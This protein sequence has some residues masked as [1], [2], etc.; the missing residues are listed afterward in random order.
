[1]ILE[2]DCWRWLK[3][4]VFTLLIILTSCNFSNNSFD[5]EVQGHRGCRGLMPENTVPAFLKAVELGVPVLELDVVISEDKQVV[6]SHEAYFNHIIST[7]P[8]GLEITQN[9][10]KSHIL[11]Y[12]PY[13]TI[14][15]YDVGQK[16][17]PS[18]PEQEKLAVY[19]P[20]LSEVVEKSDAH[21]AELKK[22]LPK[23][24]IEIKRIKGEDHY[25]TPPVEVFVDLVLKEVDRL[26]IHDRAIIQS[27][28]MESL[29]LVKDNAPALS[30]A[31]LIQ[32]RNSAEDNI[33]ALGFKPDIYSSFFNA[34]DEE[35]VQFCHNQDIKVIPWTVNKTADI[36]RMVL[37]KVDGIIS[38][39]PNR[40]FDL[41][42][43]L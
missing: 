25:Y 32:N 27:F 8:D 1:M 10:Q 7:G 30:I 15:E 24:N 21:A 41:L 16:H 42:R 13:S 19:K 40:V 43:A 9:N 33:K 26:G 22:P 12:L 37:Y 17:H 23:Y 35:L 38:D 11:Y 18:F 39:Y 14:K 36:Q 28:D 34:V 20:L 4:I 5:I 6:V 2:E 29:R 3:G 31:L